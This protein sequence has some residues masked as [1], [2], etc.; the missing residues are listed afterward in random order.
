M[1]STPPDIRTRGLDQ[2]VE[3]IIGQGGTVVPV[4]ETRY[5]PDQVIL[6]PNS[7]LAVQI[8]E[9]SDADRSRVTV[10]LHDALQS[11]HVEAIFDAGAAPLPA[12][13]D[14]GEDD[15]HTRD[16]A[17]GEYGDYDAD[18]TRVE[19]PPVHSL[20]EIVRT[21]DPVFDVADVDPGKEAAEEQDHPAA[22][23]PNPADLKNRT[24]PAEGDN[25][26]DDEDR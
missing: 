16:V 25:L 6:D 26:K 1:A 7:P 15:G 13:S 20:P 19:T 2:R 5:T 17:S 9:N 24:A 18:M 22:D 10:P 11:G 12:R 4:N 14:V 3:D 21:A 8:P 23:E